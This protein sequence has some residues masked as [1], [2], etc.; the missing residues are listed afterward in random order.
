MFATVHI[1][2]QKEGH[3]S[4][5]IYIYD[6]DIIFIINIS[7]IQL[8]ILKET[9]HLR[10]LF[11]PRFIK[12]QGTL[13]CKCKIFFVGITFVGQIP[14]VDA[15]ADTICHKNRIFRIKNF[16][17]VTLKIKQHDLRF[18]VSHTIVFC[19]MIHFHLFGI[20]GRCDHIIHFQCC[21]VFV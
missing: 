14:A 4:A 15:K 5:G 18:C 6:A 8:S 1:T 19:H 20:T 2:A 11:R 12:P 21:R 17:C 3:I 9:E 16:I 7:R 13:L 10:Q